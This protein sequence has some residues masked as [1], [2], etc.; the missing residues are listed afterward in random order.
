MRTAGNYLPAGPDSWNPLQWRMNRT[1]SLLPVMSP[2][3]G[4][5]C[6]A[7]VE[8]DARLRFLIAADPALP[9]ARL[10]LVPATEIMGV[11]PIE[12]MR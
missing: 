8:D 7:R 12:E 11:E 1:V 5:A 3:L 9:D 10:T 2:P 6:G 4:M